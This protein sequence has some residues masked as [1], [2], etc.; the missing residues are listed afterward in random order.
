M[1]PARRHNQPNASHVP[2]MKRSLADA[3]VLADN[4]QA[5]PHGCAHGLQRQRRAAPDTGFDQ[6]LAR[7]P[8]V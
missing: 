5:L 6:A 1:I 7:I 3:V 8:L 2:F 4:L